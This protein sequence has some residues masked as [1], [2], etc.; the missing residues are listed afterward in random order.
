MNT[1]ISTPEIAQALN[2][3]CQCRT[4]NEPLLHRLLE[5]DSALA[6]KWQSVA[7]TRPHLFASTAVFLSPNTVEQVVQAVTTLERVIA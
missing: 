3:A 6:G 7:S 1:T 4:I 2:Q 5:A